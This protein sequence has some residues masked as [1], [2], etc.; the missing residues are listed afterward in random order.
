MLPTS[1]NE[2]CGRDLIFFSNKKEGAI[3][4]ITAPLHQQYTISFLFNCDKILKPAHRID[5]RSDAPDAAFSVYEGDNFMIDSEGIVEAVQDD[6]PPVA[7]NIRRKRAVKPIYGGVKT[8]DLGYLSNY[9]I[10]LVLAD[11]LQIIKGHQRR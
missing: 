9:I 7:V 4:L 6:G 2:G 10:E 11:K 8:D 3:K 1:Q 5:I